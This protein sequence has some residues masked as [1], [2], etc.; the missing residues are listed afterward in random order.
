MRRYS[1]QEA[2]GLIAIPFYIANVTADKLY[3]LMELPY[4]VDLEGVD[5]RYETTANADNVGTFAAKVGSTVHAQHS[6]ADGTKAA[7][8][9]ATLQNPVN[10]VVALSAGDELDLDFSGVAGTGVDFGDVSIT[11]YLRIKG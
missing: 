1:Q 4:D 2:Q 9:E 6:M 7:W 3:K 11:A 5:I 8:N 10:D